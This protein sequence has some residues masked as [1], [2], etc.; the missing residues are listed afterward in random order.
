M[1]IV[2]GEFDSLLG[3][4][5]AGHELHVSTV[6]SASVRDLRR[7]TR[8]A[9]ACCTWLFLSLDHDRPGAE[10]V[11]SWRDRYPSK[12]RRVILPR[13]KD[14]SEFVAGGGDVTAWLREVRADFEHPTLSRATFDADTARSDRT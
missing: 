12:A 8:S 4:Q 13:G 1:L 9:L 10:A 14:L 2:E 6:G 3:N 5:I 7:E 11:R